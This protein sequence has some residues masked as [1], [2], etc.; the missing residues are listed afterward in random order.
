MNKPLEIKLTSLM[1]NQLRVLYDISFKDLIGNLEKDSREQVPNYYSDETFYYLD[2]K[3]TD[4][5]EI[6][7]IFD[8]EINELDKAHIINNIFGEIK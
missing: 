6:A 1:I 8:L 4:K 7:K 3:L 5:E 2:G